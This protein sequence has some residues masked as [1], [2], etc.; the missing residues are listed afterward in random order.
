MMRAWWIVLAVACG[1]GG[2]SHVDAHLGD[3]PADISADAGLVVT[4]GSGDPTFGNDGVL[5]HAFGG[6]AFPGASVVL[7]SGRLLVPVSGGGAGSGLLVAFAPDGAIDTSFGSAGTVVLDQDSDVLGALPDGSLVLATASSTFKTYE[8]LLADGSLDQAYG[9]SGRVYGGFDLGNGPVTLQNSDLIPTVADA[10]GRVYLAAWQTDNHTVVSRL[11]ASGHPD[12]TFGPYGSVQAGFGLPLLLV[13]EPDGSLWM[14]VAHDQHTLEFRH[15]LENGTVDPQ[16]TGFLDHV[17]QQ[18]VCGVVIAAGGGFAVAGSFQNAT[19]TYVARFSSTG[20]PDG[21][22]HGGLLDAA[23]GQC[24][25]FFDNGV[26][27][28]A[29]GGIILAVAT[30]MPR[31]AAIV[32]VD[33]SGDHETIYAPAAYVWRSVFELSDGKILGVGWSMST[34]DLVLA[35]YL[36]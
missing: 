24:A 25:S 6:T 36:P 4:M 19:R 29:N 1:G 35:R 30:G 28:R 9:G 18:P 10:S 33:G 23:D 3:A 22:Y 16:E 32:A 20:D 8:R 5:D 13:V 17:D 21:S 2:A 7:P 34:Q 26:A 27:A 15:V 14:A 31:Q 11:T 12:A